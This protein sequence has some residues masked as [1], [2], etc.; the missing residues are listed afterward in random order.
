MKCAHVH[1]Y[2]LQFIKPFLSSWEICCKNL[3]C[4]EC[5]RRKGRSGKGFGLNLITSWLRI[6]ACESTRGPRR[7]RG[8]KRVEVKEQWSLEPPLLTA[9]REAAHG[10]TRD[11]G[12]CVLCILSLNKA[13]ILLC[14]FS[15]RK[16]KLQYFKDLSKGHI[17]ANIIAWTGSEIFWWTSRCYVIL[18][19]SDFY[20]SLW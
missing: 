12:A 7:R 19:G 8:S 4:V 13:G 6:R 11:L 20:L 18:Q 16:L 10:I 17:L 15:S 14:P 1:T 3:I 5:R 9:V 2:F